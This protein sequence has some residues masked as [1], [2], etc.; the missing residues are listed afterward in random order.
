M[1]A[2][3]T[4]TR[5]PACGFTLIEV[6]VVLF[7]IGLMMSG[8]VAFIT[9]TIANRRIEVTRTKQ[10]AIKTALIT[11][12]AR[13]YRLPCPALATLA[14]GA[15]NEGVEATPSGGNCTGITASGSSPNQVV[16]GAVPWVSLG[17]TREVSLDAYTYRFT[18]QVVLGATGLTL[19]TVS[20]MT[21]RITVHSAG[22]G[23]LEAAPTGNQ[24]NDCS[25]GATVNPCAGVA[26]IVSHGKDGYGAY[27]K[28]GSQIAFESTVTGNDAR[29]NA[30]GDRMFVVK[31]YS[32]TDANPF[33]DIV[34]VLTTNDLLSPL[35]IGGTLKDYRATLN[36]K[37]DVIKGAV[38]ADA[39]KN[40]GLKNGGL[41]ECNRYY[42]QP[43]SMTSLLSTPK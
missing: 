35:V 21:G 33:D 15:A 37:I 18:Y 39:Y 13:N 1:N 17:L 28:S 22:L 27:T 38:I 24:T 8:I 20:G 43:N 34:M 6:A 29:E 14:E 19:S 32:G 5:E 23:I 36:A 3:H 40:V 10:E 30:N 31:D 4:H 42:Q 26:V 25:G 12:I 9:S 2:P 16:T 41:E 11:F 7:I